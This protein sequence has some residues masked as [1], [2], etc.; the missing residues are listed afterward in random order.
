MKDKSR[1]RVAA[2]VIALVQ[3]QDISSVYDYSVSK[4]RSISATHDG[5]SLNGYDYDTRSHFSGSGDT[6]FDYE[7]NSHV[8]LTVDR[9]GF[10]GYDYHTNSH[11]SGTVNS[12]SV[13]LYDYGTSK[14]YNFS[15]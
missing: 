6:F 15:G 11:F 3:R 1:A 5:S 10:T 7:T 8:Q 2:A 9:Q 14:Y 13:S 12:G 4:H